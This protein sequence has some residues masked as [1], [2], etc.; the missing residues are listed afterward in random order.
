MKEVEPS[1]L[2]F[3]EKEEIK[4]L[5]ERNPHEWTV[6][7]LSESFPAL[8]ATIKKVLHAK[9]S[10]KS[11]ETVLRYDEKVISNW[12]AFRA[13]EL[14]L[15]P[16]MAKHLENFKDRQIIQTD[17][18][19][20]AKRYVPSKMEFPKP[21][22][23]MFSRIAKTFLSP[24]V[25]KKGNT[26]D[27]DTDVEISNNDEDKSR[28][29]EASEDFDENI[30]RLK[31]DQNLEKKNM[32]LKTSR[33]FDKESIHSKHNKNW[34]NK[35][36]DLKTNQNFDYKNVRLNSDRNWANNNI[37][38]ETSRNFNEE[39]VRFISNR[40]WSDKSMDFKTS[41]NLDYKSRSF[42]T[43]VNSGYKNRSF[44]ETKNGKQFRSLMIE[45]KNQST[46]VVCPRDENQMTLLSQNLNEHDPRENNQPLTFDE[47][48]IKNVGRTKDSSNPEDIVL[49]ETYKRHIEKIEFERNSASFSPSE[50]KTQEKDFKSE[51]EVSSVERNMS[52]I[53]LNE[54]EKGS[55]SKISMRKTRRNEVSNCSQSQI[56]VS[57][58]EDSEFSLSADRSGVDTYVKEW[59][60]KGDELHDE[61]LF[62]KIPKHRYKEGMTY[63]VQNCYYDDDGEFLY[64][65]PGLHN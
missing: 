36:I 26:G 9:W 20:L 48:L 1:F 12:E 46:E 43:N 19:E 60:K 55:E 30:L 44:E 34:D 58:K 10:P 23:N 7:K 49:K 6:E 45:E 39:N 29:F 52:S 32:Y 54:E 40:N 8:P 62:I 57:K 33:N 53:S 61:P 28:D 37:N 22:S 13:G 2:T 4:S 5:H 27:E 51:S 14:P 21:R 41:R 59:I 42:E 3:A 64:K 18:E 31:S 17:R 25:E 16:T 24:N 63:R 50:S 38:L 47:F 11:V 65:V 56:D 15:S 35:N